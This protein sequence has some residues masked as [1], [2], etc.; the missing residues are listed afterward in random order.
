MKG[1]FF[2]LG[3]V[4][5][6]VA[7]SSGI[8]PIRGAMVSIP[9]EDI[10][11]FSSNLKS[12]FPRAF[13]F[14]LQSGTPA[15]TLSSFSRF[16]NSTLLEHYMN[17]STFWV[18]AKGDGSTTLQFTAGNFLGSDTSLH[19]N[20]NGALKSISVPNNSTNSVTFTGVPSDFNI[21]IMYGDESDTVEWVRD[22]GNL[23]CLFKIIRGRDSNREEFS[24]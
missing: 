14:G 23:Y 21:T 16:V 15:Q 20:L 24:V 9:T 7:L 5:L 1:Q 12:E 8:N 11:Y 17:F 2:I 6:I 18:Y 4:I 13:N 22:K 10:P 3:A 19:L